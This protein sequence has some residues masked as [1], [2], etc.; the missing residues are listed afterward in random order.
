VT[1]LSLIDTLREPMNLIGGGGGGGG[2]VILLLGNM[3]RMNDN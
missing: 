2:N 1:Q 3:G